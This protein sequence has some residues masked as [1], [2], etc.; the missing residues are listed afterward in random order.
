MIANPETELLVVDTE[1]KS[2]GDI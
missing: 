2:A 1:V